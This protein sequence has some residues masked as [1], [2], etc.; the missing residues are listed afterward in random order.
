V[1]SKRGFLRQIGLII[2]LMLII[3]PL[4]SAHAADVPRDKTLII[5]FEGGPAQ[6]PENF[7][8][9]A[10]ALNS[11]GVHQVMI[12]SLYVLNY[13]TGK[14][15]PW[16]AADTEKWNSDYTAFD[17]PLRKGVMWNDGQ[18]FTADDVVFSLKMYKAHPSLIFGAAIADGVKDV[19]ATD[20]QTV[21]VVLNKANPRFV[22]DNFSVRI[23]GAVRIVPKHIWEGQDPETF[24][25]F[26]LAKGWPVWTGPYKLVKASATEF[27]FDRDD[28]WWAAKTGF[29]KLPAPQRVVFVD[30]GPEDRKAA[31]LAANEVDGEPSLRID[32]F[33]QVQ[34]QNPQVIGWTKTAPSAWI[35]PCPG[36]LG[37]N[38]TK[39][40]WDDAD[41][42][43]AVSYAI[44]KQKIADAT[45]GGFGKLASFNF[46]DYPALQSWLTENQDLLKK[47]D[48]TVFDL[49]KAKQIIESK[50]Y[51][52]GSDGFY[53]KDGKQLAV[54]VLVKSAETIATPI[55]ISSLQDAG[56]N[57]TPRAL[58]DASYFLARQKRD[59]DIETTHVNCG[60]VTEPFSELV[61]LHS[62]WIK[63]DGQIQDPNDWGY[64]NPAYDKIVDAIGA[65]P[66][67]DPKEHAL[68]RQ[69]LEIRLKDLPIFPLSQQLRIVP[70][71]T[72]Y[73]TNWPTADNG[74]VHPPNWW[75]TF[76]IPLV[77][78]KSASAS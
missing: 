36:I 45:S 65:L 61:T 54:S 22:Y 23:W 76:I 51:K 52:M 21:H 59:F 19:T 46:P 58:V 69:A 35:D 5:G 37:F 9:N 42:R 7:G 49:A 38:T 29:Q 13:Q 10:T 70:Y 27:D 56:I 14:A 15:E 1:N 63:P 3:A 75:Q 26:D 32:L 8:L 53:A 68:F 67:N 4:I 40:P 71:T 41:M 24:T 12:E 31:A 50:G 77:N 25:N 47:Y 48:S 60:S 78:I 73:W 66:P 17:I 20:P 74:Y 2:A 33:G 57:A 6:A 43:W 30:A 11:Q 18:P 55:I 34:S 16:L 39:A 28:N 44:P 62:K 72:K 64:K